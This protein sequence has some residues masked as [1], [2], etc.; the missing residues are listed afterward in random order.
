MHS[1]VLLAGRLSGPDP[2]GLPTGAPNTLCE[3]EN[4]ARKEIVFML[5][6]AFLEIIL[7][8]FTRNMIFCLKNT[9]LSA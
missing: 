3:R 2:E 6:D 9:D 5:S 7:P 1:S 4:Y 8:N